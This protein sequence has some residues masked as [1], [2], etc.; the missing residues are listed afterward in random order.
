VNSYSRSVACAGLLVLIAAGCQP[1][2]GH[3]ERSENPLVV[4]S[5]N[6]SVP[7][8]G[9]SVTSIAAS[10]SPST[11][12]SLASSKPASS[13]F[14]SAI[15]GIQV[16]VPAGWEARVATERWT[17]G[18]LGYDSP[19]ADVIFDPKLGDRL[20]LL[21]ASQPYGDLSADTWR[22]EAI[23]SVCPTGGGFSSLKVDGAPA[24]SVACGPNGM[25]LVMTEGRGYVIRLVAASDEPG[26]ADTY[27]WD[28]LRNLLTTVDLHPNEA[29]VP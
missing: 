23:D 9:S 24:L 12:S 3:A 4:P 8:P 25:V 16:E 13:L 18:P 11:T 10:P 5:S 15:N 14:D 19:G 27:N 7:A 17:H 21:L 29:A 20:Y 2:S 6:S 22:N 1:P 28:W 26:L